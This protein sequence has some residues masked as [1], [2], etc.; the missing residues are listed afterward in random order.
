MTEKLCLQWNDFKDNVNHAFQSLRDDP[1]FA[2][3]TLTCEDGKQVEAHK[4]I[5][6]S[7]SPFFKDVLKRDKHPHPLIYM[8][9]LKSEDL[10]AIVDFLYFGEASVAQQNLDSF[11]SIAD[12]L[13]LV[14][15][16]TSGEEKEVVQS[17]H[18]EGE[19]VAEAQDDEVKLEVDETL[20]VSKKEDM[21]GSV[22]KK[23]F[24]K[25]EE[26]DQG[27]VAKE[28]G[29]TGLSLEKITSKAKDWRGPKTENDDKDKRNCDQ[30]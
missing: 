28:L 13:K 7:S 26:S 2:D 17:P 19:K 12:E 23:E 29:L 20:D 11:L 5:L 21:M 24:N 30:E 9:G 15:L 14:G 18:L 27:S 6:A 4:V 16:S 3:V 25:S 10:V 1:D 22:A 8:R